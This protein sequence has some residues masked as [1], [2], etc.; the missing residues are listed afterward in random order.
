MFC[1]LG[2]GKWDFM[3][4]EYIVLKIRKYASTELFYGWGRTCK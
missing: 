3:Y 4:F 1:E 2:K